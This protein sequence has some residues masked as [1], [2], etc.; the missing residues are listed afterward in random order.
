M[1]T[2]RYSRYEGPAEEIELEEL[3]QHLQELLLESG[4]NNDPW[5]PDPEA[6]REYADLLAAIAAALQAGGLVP[7]ELISEALDADDWHET[8][9]GQLA[10]RLAERLEQAG[11]IRLLPAGGA[12]SSSEPAA[13]ALT[14]RTVALLGNSALEQIMGFRAGQLPG[15]HLTRQSGSG[16]E[17]SSASR[18]YVFGDTGSLDAAAT[19]QSAA[20]RGSTDG[21]LRIGPDDLHVQESEFSTRVATVLMLDCSHSMILYGEDRFTPGKRVALALA[22]LI[23]SRYRGDS[24]R[25]VLFHDSAEEVTLEQLAGMQVGPFHTN[26]AQ[27]LK[28]ARRLLAREQADSR[29][30]IMVTDGKPTAITLPGGRIYRNAYGQDALVLSETLREATA[31]R[32]SGITVSTFMLADDPA[33][34]AFVRQVTELTRGRAFL[35]DAAGMGRFV[36]QEF[37]R[38]RSRH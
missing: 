12:G 26:T 9:L 25:F 32:R 3:L 15:A 22:Q 28:L 20:L 16:T 31:C 36:L 21:K 1:R 35:T 37:S 18:P 2:I 17:S 14:S 6:G 5:D 10:M 34:L 19:L 30:I 27:G 13:F 29:Q 33:L 38:S 24:L 4:F 23:R 7:Q 8:R 11:W